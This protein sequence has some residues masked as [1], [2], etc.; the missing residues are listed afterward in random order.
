MDNYVMFAPEINDLIRNVEE[1]TRSTEEGVK[2]FVEPA[3]GTLSRATSRRHHVVFGRRGSGKSSL[4]R[5]AAADLTVDRRPIAYVDLESFKGHSYPDVLISVL[6]KT[7]AEFKKWLETAAIHPAT[8]T[9]FWDRLFGS[10]PNRSAFNKSKAEILSNKLGRYIEELTEL[11]H[12]SD[13]TEISEISRNSGEATRTGKLDGSFNAKVAQASGSAIESKT[14]ASGN[15]KQVTYLRSKTDFLHRH[16]MEYQSLFQ[17]M[18]ELSDGAAYLFLDDLYH[19]RR[20]DQ[21]SVIDY[22]H[23]V[24]K[25]NNLWLKI[26]TIRHRT[27]WYIHGD[28][29]IGLKMGDDAEDID[30]DLTLEKYAT[31]KDFLKKILASFLKNTS[32]LGVYDILT[33]GALD[34]LV[35][36]SGGV[37]RDFL[38][39]FR[40]SVSFARERLQSDPNHHRGKKV[41]AED[42]NNASGEYEAK[43]RDELSRDTLDDRAS[44]ESEFAAVRDF[45]FNQAQS[46]IFLT[47]KDSMEGWSH[48]VQELVDLRLVHKVNSR[49]TV[50][51]R[52]GKIYEAYMLDTSQYTG[53]RTKRNFDIHEFWHDTNRDKIRKAGLIYKEI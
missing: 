30:L 1:S 18:A 36:A 13:N 14:E 39:I 29:P 6:I 27:K 50:P 15:E 42:V 4:L 47:I 34:R 11:L 12:E 9:S 49:I 33:E 32:S 3:Y 10:K 16:I 45:C 44:L 5:K 2:R 28:P 8:K 48:N 38:N 51:G 19:I 20:S 26:G 22:F 35:L 37:S 17:E 24:A 53:S 41:S 31:T 7:F 46:N 23:R 52:V 21:A 40:Q 25:G 43:K